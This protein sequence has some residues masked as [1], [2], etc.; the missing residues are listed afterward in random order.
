VIRATVTV[1]DDFAQLHTRVQK[2]AQ[3]ATRA[4]A[5]QAAQVAQANASIDLEL[6]LIPA[7]D[8]PDGVTAG[9]R[10]KKTGSRDTRIADFFD[11]GT[12]G[13]RKKKTK[14]PGRSSWTVKRGGSSYTAHRGDTSG[15]GIPAERFFAK[16]K[17]AGRKT[18][19]AEVEKG[20]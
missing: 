11:E 5:E 8:D 13:N 9:I 20:P 17:T 10:S 7:A 3:R 15:K 1:R 12:L 6:E 16:A 18:M 19:I 4:A 2:L 14:R